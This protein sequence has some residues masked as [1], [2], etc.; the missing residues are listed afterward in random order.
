MKKNVF[1]L[2]L[3]LALFSLLIY[4]CSDSI[5]PLD[6]TD[7]VNEENSADDTDDADDSDDGNSGDDSDDERN[8]DRRPDRE[9]FVEPCHVAEVAG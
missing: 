4:S 1:Q 7:I 9:T 2:T 6:N 8:D 5:E 3:L